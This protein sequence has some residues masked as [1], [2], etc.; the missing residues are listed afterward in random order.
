ME[1]PSTP[2]TNI[3]TDSAASEPWNRPK[4]RALDVPDITQ[5]KATFNPTEA[6]TSTG[7]A[8]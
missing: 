7:N 1:Y 8:S 6:S 5:G 3:I 2:Q 4:L